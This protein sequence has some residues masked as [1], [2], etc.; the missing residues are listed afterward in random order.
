MHRK[1]RER[2]C[3]FNSLIFSMCRVLP[4][5]RSERNEN[6]A[7]DTVESLREIGEVRVYPTFPSQLRGTHCAIFAMR[8][9]DFPNGQFEDQ[10][11][12]HARIIGVHVTVRMLLLL[13]RLYKA[14]AT[15]PVSSYS[16][17][18]Q[19]YRLKRS[20]IIVAIAIVTAS[21]VFPA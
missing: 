10:F 9:E 4:R 12:V 13:Y 3:K 6:N 20:A 19:I 11:R 14:A 5:P 21:T 18:K 15:R 1:Y 17:S 2:E 7:G 8:P 16:L